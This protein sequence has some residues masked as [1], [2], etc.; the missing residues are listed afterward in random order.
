[1]GK[2]CGLR[3][4]SVRYNEDE[5]EEYYFDELEDWLTEDEVEALTA[6]CPYEIYPEDD[7]DYDDDDEEDDEEDDEMRELRI[8]WMKNYIQVIEE[9]NDGSLHI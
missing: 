1:M 6:D 2:I 4:S 5:E 7:D 9:Q 3:Y 8:A